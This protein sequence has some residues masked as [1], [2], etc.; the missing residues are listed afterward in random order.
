MRIVI[1]LQGAQS[2]SRFRGIGRYSLSLAKS[3]IENRGEH[4]ILVAL[5]GLFPDTI[6][7]LRFELE[8]MLPRE[9]IRVWHA[10]GPVKECERGNDQRR[11]IAELLRESFLASLQ[12]DMILITSLFE[13]Y[14][15]DAVTSIGRF[16]RNT[17]TAVVL[18]DLIP[19][20]NPDIYLPVQ[21]QKDHYFRKITF[22]KKAE[23]LLSI[24]ESAGREA[25]LYLDLP[26]N[27]ITNI[28][29]AVDGQF[30]PAPVC[31]NQA[32]ILKKR[33]QIKRRMILY[34]PGGFDIRK[35]FERFIEAYS[36]L[37]MEIRDRHQ[38]VIA[39]K[40]SEGNRNNLLRMAEKAKLKNDD[41]LLTGYVPD[42]D[43]I[44]LYRMAVLF[45]FPSVHEGFGLPVLEAMSCGAPV[46]GAEASSLPEVIGL[47]E[48]LFDPFDVTSI[49]DKMRKCLM[50]KSFRKRLCK[51]GLQQAGKF[52]WNETAKRVITACEAQSLANGKFDPEFS[53]AHCKLIEAVSMHLGKATKKQ[54][55][56]LAS[57]MAKNLQAGIER[58][59][60]LDVSELSMRDAATGVQRVVRSYLMWLL[61][62][63]PSG[64]RVEP[65]Y[66]TRNRGYRYARQFTRSFLGQ[67]DYPEIDDPI[68][69]QRGD[70]FFGLDMQH[71]IQLAHRDFYRQLRREGVTI[72]FMVYDLLPIQLADLFKDA[73]TTALH[74]RWLSM[75]AETDGAISISKTTADAYHEWMCKTG[76]VTGPSFQNDWVHIGADINGSQPSKGMP[77][78][79]D[80]V[81][82]IIQSRITF[83]CVATLEP[84]KKQDQI[85]SS[86][87][88]LWQEDLD[89]NLV[90][91]GQKGWKVNSL[92]DR[93][94]K[95]SENG[96]RFFW[97]KGISD[98]YLEQVYAASNCLIAASINEGFG[99]TLIEAARHGIPIIARD[100]PVFRE[101]ANQGAY[102]FSGNNPTDLAYALKDWLI[103]YMA[104][105]QPDSKKI[106]Y[107][108]WEEST[109]K[110]KKIL[111]EFNY[112]RKQLLVDIS[113]LVQRDAETGIQRVVR[114]VL[115]EWLHNPPS[116]WRIEPVYATIDHTYRYARKFIAHFLAI[117]TDGL[118]DEPVEYEPGDIFFG[119]DLQPQ[120]QTAQA[121]FY[122]N[123]RSQG[124]HV[125]FMLFDL[126]C[127]Q[128]PEYFDAG[129][130]NGFSNWL[131]V[132]C[133]N[134]GVI[135]ISQTVAKELTTWMK[136]KTWQRNLPFTID[137][138]HLGADF[139]NA[140]PSQGLPPNAD[141]MLTTLIQQPTFLMVGTIEPRKGHKDVLDAFD[142]LW[143]E[144]MEIHLVIVGKQGWMVE[145]LIDRLRTH[146]LDKKRLFW[147]EHISDEY[148]EK[149]Y[150]C[151]L[152]LIAASHG[153]G[154]GLPLIEA[155]QHR[156]PII[157][158]DLPVF[159]EVAG[160]HAHYF[161][162]QAPNAL[163]DAIKTWLDLHQKNRLPKSENMPWLS[164]RESADNLARLVCN[165]VHPQT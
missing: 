112:P 143:Q 80:T 53:T 38:L 140:A 64:F 154:F 76:T 48:A 37:P 129:S 59:L 87:E 49:T 56:P 92:A 110:L 98:E 102:Y 74:S 137:W 60:L 135:C 157:A 45:V 28:S 136:G 3:I 70:I 5:S 65:V 148:L 15:D 100:I 22:A 32:T 144:G 72:K 113:E 162:A 16:D 21:S 51:N 128:Q 35:N 27:R 20:S 82:Q 106:R 66:A 101:V 67:K 93:I 58:Q 57:C 44:A 141:Q 47:N 105:K 103:L 99:L 89:V 39:S 78:D 34:V 91:V 111:I 11:E 159:R 26:T 107:S 50:E 117:T 120:V 4:D 94:E 132:V 155:A 31:E 90:F 54:L 19:F 145:P 36:L 153:E 85:L 163:A 77:L 71:H 79:A 63:P 124:I 24:S 146:P 104:G 25:I 14:V 29:S 138:N 6:M 165:S 109:K 33:Y 151:S 88:Q 114:S 8:K 55:L 126:L 130:V 43:L 13:G 18:Y 30:S 10:P 42:E 150:E 152:C 23:Q 2:E 156:L 121:E 69:W 73:D 142:Q 40:I 133:E 7:P 108:T 68:R 127:I 134:D 116:G 46:I 119:L 139:E 61:H 96:L 161:N 147:L 86:L 149:I 17:K 123:L 95:H 83:L 81:L 62:T 41:L 75:L 9:K 97:L 12:P 125:K 158:R 122:Q 1:D 52:S 164:W 118:V 84:R 160:D 131:K 115:K